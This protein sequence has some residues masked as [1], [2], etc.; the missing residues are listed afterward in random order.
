M[1][2]TWKLPIFRVFFMIQADKELSIST[3]RKH[4]DQHSKILGSNSSNAKFYSQPFYCCTYFFPG[5]NA[6]KHHL[7]RF[8]FRVAKV[9]GYS[10]NVKYNKYSPWKVVMNSRLQFEILLIL[11]DSRVLKVNIR[12]FFNFLWGSKLI[13]I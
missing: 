4:L 12:V 8:T 10:K 11:S 3:Y 6:W 7:A 5:K 2:I 1:C 13:Q 9:W